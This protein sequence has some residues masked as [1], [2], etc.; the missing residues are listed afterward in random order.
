MTKSGISK[1]LQ[2]ELNKRDPLE[3]EW[4]H[5]LSRPIFAKTLK[6]RKMAEDNI[7]KF[8]K[9]HPAIVDKVHNRKWTDPY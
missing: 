7:K 3:F 2:E 8:R 6:Q 9:K 1:E 5:L 4:G